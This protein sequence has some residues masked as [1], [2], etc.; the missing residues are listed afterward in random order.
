MEPANPEAVLL[1]NRLERLATYRKTWESHWQEIA[2]YVIPRKAD[3][4]QSRTPGDK[5]ME[6]VFDGTAIHAAELLSA[7][8]HGMLTNPSTTWFDLRYLDDE[9][10]TDDESKEYLETVTD[11]MLQEFQRSNFG[12]QIH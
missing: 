8:I 1:M 12:E 3:I 7:S 10:N 6:K 4:T 11:I 5:R 9:L 2:D